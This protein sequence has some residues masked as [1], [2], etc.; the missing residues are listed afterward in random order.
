MRPL[1]R[2]GLRSGGPAHPVRDGA[3]SRAPPPTALR[4]RRTQP[5]PGPVFA[6]RL[7]EEGG[8]GALRAPTHDARGFLARPLLS[9]PRLARPGAL[10]EPDHPPLPDAP[11]RPALRREACRRAF[12]EIGALDDGR[13]A[14]R[15]RRADCG[16]PR[17]LRR[18][19][20]RWCCA[21]PTGRRGVAPRPRSPPPLLA[22]AGLSGD[23]VD[24]PTAG[25]L[26]GADG[27]ARSRDM[28]ALAR[29]WAGRR[30]RDCD[31]RPEGLFPS[32]PWCAG[33]SR[34]HRPGAA[35][36]RWWLATAAARR[37]RRTW[38]SV[39]STS[40][41]WPEMRRRG[42]VGAGPRR[43][44]ALSPEN[45]RRCSLR[46]H[47]RARRGRFDAKAKAAAAGAP[48]GASGR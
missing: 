41:R 31:A 45:R 36:G 17:A 46:R 16:A 11:P 27:R 32:A 6:W 21:P 30:P 38:R 23:D 25:R 29:G 37:W 40:S 5:H 10:G 26:R 22:S 47:R 4:P 1:P 42:G 9:S 13:A 18:G 35:A 34:S 20:R 14:Y 12:S 24:S 7:W 43:R 19:S 8:T 15:A 44:G 33:L 3:R 48:C 28:R 2:A 39:A